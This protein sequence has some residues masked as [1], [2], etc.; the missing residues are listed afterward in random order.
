MPKIVNAALKAIGLETKASPW[1][2][3]ASRPRTALRTTSLFVMA[4]PSNA[5][6]TDFSL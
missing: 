2:Q 4:Q 5:P 3:G 6:E 1:P